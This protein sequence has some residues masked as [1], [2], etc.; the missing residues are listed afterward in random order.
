[1]VFGGSDLIAAL[2]GCDTGCI[3]QL[4]P[5][6]AGPVPA[7]LDLSLVLPQSHNTSR[8]LALAPNT[9]IVLG[10]EQL[11]LVLQHGLTVRLAADAAVTLPGFSLMAVR[12][13]PGASGFEQV[14]P[15]SPDTWSR[16]GTAVTIADGNNASYGG[17]AAPLVVVALEGSGTVGIPLTVSTTPSNVVSLLNVRATFG[18]TAATMPPASVA[19]T[20][21]V[22]GARYLL[23]FAV[24]A[25]TT[26]AQTLCLAG[27]RLLTASEDIGTAH[28]E[29]ALAANSRLNATIHLL[30]LQVDAVAQ[31]RALPTP[32]TPAAE[33]STDLTPTPLPYTTVDAWSTTTP[34]LSLAQLLANLDISAYEALPTASDDASGLTFV[35]YTAETGIVAEFEVDAASAQTCLAGCAARVDCSGLVIEILTSSDL[36]CSYLASLGTT[37]TTSLPVQLL[38]LRKRPPT[39]DSATSSSPS[40]S[41]TALADTTTDADD[42]SAEPAVVPPEPQITSELRAEFILAYASNGTADGVV[43]R[44]YLN[45]T[46][47]RGPFEYEDLSTCFTACADAPA[48]CAAVILTVALADPTKWACNFVTATR[49]VGVPSAEIS[50]SYV[51]RSALTT[52]TALPSTAHPTTTF[53]STS[54]A[55][56][57]TTSPMHFGRDLM[58]PHYELVAE[59]A[60]SGSNTAATGTSFRFVAADTE[61][62]MDATLAEC[63]AAC[64]QSGTCLSL[65]LTPPRFSDASDMYHCTL[66]R[67]IG[68]LVTT[69]TRSLC[70]I[71][72]SVASTPGPDSNSTLMAPVVIPPAVA[73]YFAAL[74]PDANV[75]GAGYFGWQVAT[76]DDAV[77]TRF[78]AVHPDA[79]FGACRSAAQCVAL[80]VQAPSTSGGNPVCVL[81]DAEVFVGYSTHQRY[82]FRLVAPTVD[83]NATT[84]T[85]APTTPLPPVTVPAMYSHVFVPTFEGTQTTNGPPLVYAAIDSAAAVIS[86]RRAPQTPSKCFTAC[87][88]EPTCSH[89]VIQTALS[90][91]ECYLLRSA[92]ASET[93]TATTTSYSYRRIPEDSSTS[94]ESTTTATSNVAST[95]ITTTISATELR[96][97]LPEAFAA[98]FRLAYVGDNA[99]SQDEPSLEF[100]GLD[101]PFTWLLQMEGG[102][103][104]E[105]CLAACLAEDACAAVHLAITAGSSIRCTLFNQVTRARTARDPSYSLVR[106]TN[107]TTAAPPTVPPNVEVPSEFALDF[108]IRHRGG[109]ADY[110][111]FA[112]AYNSQAILGESNLNVEVCLNL[113]KYH[114]RCVGVFVY[115]PQGEFRCNMLSDLGD[116]VVADTSVTYSFA[117]LEDSTTSTTTLIP[118][119]SSQSTASTLE[120]TTM[121]ST[122]FPPTTIE[123]RWHLPTA[124]ADEFRLA[125]VGDNADSTDEPS[126]EFEAMD[127]P[128]AWITQMEGGTDGVACLASCLDTPACVAVHLAVDDGNELLCTLLNEVT[129]ARTARQPSYSLVR[130]TNATTAIPPTAPPDL[131]VP[132][133]FADAFAVQF[134][135]GQ[136]TALRFSTAYASS[137]IIGE[138]RLNLEVCL[139]M[140]NRR[141][142]CLGV[143][144]YYPMGAFRCNLLRSLGAAPVSDDEVTY[145]IGKLISTTTS[146]TTVAASHPSPPSTTAAPS[147]ALETS[148]STVPLSTTVEPGV[149]TTETGVTTT[150]TGVTTTVSSGSSPAQSTSTSEGTSPFA[151]ST[152]GPAPSTTIQGSTE[153]SVTAAP[154]TSASTGSGEDSTTTVPLSSTSTLATNLPSTSTLGLASTSTTS[155]NNFPS[156][157]SAFENDFLLAHEST[158]LGL[159]TDLAFDLNLHSSAFLQNLTLDEDSFSVCVQS[160]SLSVNCAAF[161]VRLDLE[162]EPRTVSCLL[163]RDANLPVIPDL[164]RSRSY[165]KTAQSFFNYTFYLD[166]PYDELAGTPERRQ[167]LRTLIH[168]ALAE[169]G[170]SLNKATIFIQRG[171]IVVTV[172]SSE[173]EVASVRQAVV[174]GSVIIQTAQGPIVAQPVLDTTANPGATSVPGVESNRSSKGD[175][176]LAIGLGVAIAAVVLLLIILLVVLMQHRRDTKGRYVIDEAAKP[177]EIVT[178]LPAYD[179]YSAPLFGTDLDRSLARAPSTKLTDQDHDDVYSLHSF[180]S[181]S[182]LME[183]TTTAPTVVPES[184]AGIT[185]PP[186]TRPPQYYNTI[187]LSPATTTDTELGFPMTPVAGAR[188]NAHSPVHFDT[189]R[190]VMASEARSS[191][192]SADV[193]ALSSFRHDGHQQQP[194]LILDE[195][196]MFGGVK[197]V[198]V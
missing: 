27:P 17:T 195:S 102:M 143:F 34:P 121:P 127:D 85:S 47:T 35:G 176:T 146:T 36:R 41:T 38:S 148:A 82:S 78:T 32:S 92:S 20:L 182:M 90:S 26:P 170:A 158:G 86:F 48:D 196:K 162:A 190:P 14:L 30:D 105:V 142:E 70:F 73:E 22:A 95:T 114:E 12:C 44:D 135:G 167:A 10:P 104:G 187:P 197:E 64:D 77:L 61:L 5:H 193:P 113:C 54:V 1:M 72:Q 183:S 96:W 18:L 110:A 37:Q 126:L 25:E 88:N 40:T 2:G 84:T 8:L 192:P 128:F 97:S 80:T 13:A 147:T 71:H 172:Q 16:D 120:A 79:C 175:S 6:V 89:L 15:N 76:G 153:T 117:K 31:P 43:L 132:A 65:H 49:G 140:C 149:T 93:R 136:G 134:K 69:S 155:L 124:F 23:D 174:Q 99:D 116:T 109:Q 166:A 28:L 156:L 178:D 19:M 188:P 4:V 91:F 59:G 24:F 152:S 7:S 122:P 139:D 186:P 157:P 108:A 179:N 189:P 141:P 45:A 74:E 180:K 33:L 154:S 165:I 98:D 177:D 194:V 29:I 191:S 107:Q 150:D 184:D 11:M 87:A 137:S 9:S 94:P 131:T 164:T 145:S 58:L 171:S 63:T 181:R 42:G 103:D 39:T 66:L 169:A 3:D 56:A 133:A 144:A 129:R 46:L 125:Y 75:S 138:V 62:Q 57:T 106:W 53:P 52:P 115:Y 50:R 160:C 168:E 161:Y 67:S 159:D 68:A 123:L 163:L 130:R 173:E 112:T 55:P 21:V 51:R 118:R 151:S 60:Y 111:R 100:E 101:D 119:S 185:T 81:L 198:S 83:P